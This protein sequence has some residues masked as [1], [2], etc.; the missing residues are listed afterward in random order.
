M[1]E[2]HLHLWTVSYEDQNCHQKWLESGKQRRKRFVTMVVMVSYCFHTYLLHSGCKRNFST[3]AKWRT[4]WNPMRSHRSLSL[5]VVLTWFYIIYYPF[6]SHTPIRPHITYYYIMFITWKSV[7][8]DFYVARVLAC[9]SRRP[10]RPGAG[11]Y[12]GTFIGQLWWAQQIMFKT[13][14]L[15]HLPILMPMSFITWSSRNAVQKWETESN[16]G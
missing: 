8:K 14:L 7:K 10:K 5:T 12:D 11:S 15:L 2:T 3:S 6:A 1:L 4:F 13:A 16:V 9:R